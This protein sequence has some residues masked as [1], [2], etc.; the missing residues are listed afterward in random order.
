MKCL[1]QQNEDNFRFTLSADLSDL[2]IQEIQSTN[3]ISWSETVHAYGVGVEV[4]IY[5]HVC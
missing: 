4:G 3:I 5:I 1:E 2:C